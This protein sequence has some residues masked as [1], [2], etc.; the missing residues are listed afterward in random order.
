MAAVVVGG[1]EE[2]T[3]IGDVTV[4]EQT[5]MVYVN[6]GENAALLEKKTTVAEVP[7]GDGTTAV[8]VEVT[9]HDVRGTEQPNKQELGE[10]RVKIYDMKFK[11]CEDTLRQF[12]GLERGVGV[13]TGMAT[14]HLCILVLEITS[15]DLCS[16]LNFEQRIMACR[17]TSVWDGNPVVGRE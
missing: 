1:C 3:Q 10:L 16:V 9:V 13:T 7:Q 14:F 2:V 12:N 17:S 6:D 5:E 4:N 15:D 11:L 8:L